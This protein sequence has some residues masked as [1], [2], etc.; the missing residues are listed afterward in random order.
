MTEPESPLDSRA[1]VP[2]LRRE[3][4][5]PPEL[6]ERVVSRLQREHLLAEPGQLARIAGGA[7]RRAAWPLALAAS[8]LAFAAG[9]A[10]D[11]AFLPP[12][13]PNAM[14]AAAATDP[15]A[16]T[17][18]SGSA[19]TDRAARRD[20]FAL[21]LY[22]GADFATNAPAEERARVAE[23]RAW[24]ESLASEGRP[25]SGEKLDD[26]ASLV[27]GRPADPGFEPG[28]LLGFFVIAADDLEHAARLAAA[29]PHA[30]YGGVIEVRAVARGR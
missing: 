11:R 12:P 10:V 19:T 26:R 7:G 2:E 29:S 18:T 20:L 17:Q 27:G 9:V 8:V 5:P 13:A 1:L 28:G 25:A 22:A 24:M 30:R 21:L 14:A 23:Y 6:E 3:L 4:P 16:G 15:G